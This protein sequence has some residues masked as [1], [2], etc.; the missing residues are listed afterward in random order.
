MSSGD[1]QPVQ[2]VGA[3]IES[4]PYRRFEGQRTTSWGA[5]LAVAVES[6]RSVMGLGLKARSKILPFGLVGWA[7][8]QA[9]PTV[10]LILGNSSQQ[11]ESED[12]SLVPLW[13]ML[14]MG[15]Q[16]FLFAAL[17]APQVLTH[18]RATGMLGMYFS[19]PLSRQSYVLAKSIALTSLL[20]AFVLVPPLLAVVALAVRGYAAGA[21]ASALVRTLVVG[22]T[23]AV[24]LSGVALAVSSFTN[25]R[26]SASVAFLGLTLGSLIPLAFVALAARSTDVFVLLNVVG[27][28]FGFGAL[29]GGGSTTVMFDMGAAAPVIGVLL[30]TA[31]GYGSFWARYRELQV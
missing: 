7:Y 16:F 19:T 28:L 6:A 5:V 4:S 9:L 25:R 26:A 18:D 24:V 1:P 17:A 27:A 31:A 13:L 22:L 20:S 3:F 21:V 14:S 29:V 2:Q 30:W 8:L 10:I 11:N 23:V 15:F 12:I